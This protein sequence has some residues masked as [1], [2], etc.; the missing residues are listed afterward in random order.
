MT[1]WQGEIDTLIILEE[2]RAGDSPKARIHGQQDAFE[3]VVG[4][5]SAEKLSR[6]TAATQGRSVRPI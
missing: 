5:V 1:H 6:S 3:V 4:K 2:Q